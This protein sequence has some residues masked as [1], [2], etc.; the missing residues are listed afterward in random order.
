MTP[1]YED[2]EDDYQKATSLT[3]EFDVDSYNAYLTAQ[4]CLSLEEHYTIGNVS[5][6]RDK[7]G[8]LIGTAHTNPLLDTRIYEVEFPD[9]QVLEYTANVI[10]ENLYAQVDQEGRHQVILDGIVGHRNDGSAVSPD[11]QIIVVNGK[12]CK[13][14]S[15]AGWDLCIQW[16]DG[17]TSWEKLS[18]LKEAYPVETVEYAVANK[19]AS[20]PASNWWVPYTL[21]HRDCIIASINSCYYK[22]TH[23]FGIELPKTIQQAL[24]IDKCTGSTYWYD[25][26]QKEMC[27]VK[28]AFNILNEGENVPVGYQFVKCHM[29]IEVK[30]GTLQR[31]ACLVA[32]RHMTDP[33]ASQT[34]ASVVSR[35]SVRIGLLLAA[36]NS[37]NVL[38]GDLQNAYL[39]TPCE[40]KV[41]TICG[42]EFAPEYQGSKTLL[43]RAL[44]GLKSAGASFHNHLASCLSQLGFTSCKAD[45]DEWLRAFNDEKGCECY[46]YLLVYTDDIM[47]ICKDPK[48]VLQ[49]IDKYFKVKDKSIHPPNIY[50]GGKLR[51]VT[52]PSGEICWGQ[53]ASKY[54]QEAVRNLENWLK[55][56]NNKLHTRCDT[57]M[58]TSYWPELDT[59][60]QLNAK[61]TNYYQSAIGVLRWAVEL[62][63]IDITTK[64]SMLASQMA[65]PRVG[66]FNAVL[67]IFTYLKSKHNSRI[68]FDPMMPQIAE[69]TFKK[70]TWVNFYG[71]IS[72][73]LP[74]NAPR[75]K[76]STVRLVAYVD[77][78]HAADQLT[79]Q[80]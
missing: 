20:E 69:G 7:D 71:D 45:P 1:E 30:M 6:K 57:P 34:F 21:Q 3:N 17:S 54:V 58:S 39:N 73:A 5:R 76:G 41:W 14:K 10:A 29:V 35:E 19:I 22:T 36:L 80:S 52:L 24:D 50:L 74:R 27:N 42:P 15:T 13:R 75:P 55:E 63:R 33:P 61:M 32:G 11:D 25:A 79:R 78:D 72:E 51:P 46:E 4:V 70:H 68:V 62:G 31:K 23:K 48:L 12:N 53:S 26:I 38:T 40:E 8:H 28:V 59:S 60:E 37:L 16:N 66:H 49:R 47:V 67:H 44:Y 56:Q 43:C 65:L 77:A 64:V 2:Y 9:G 18:A